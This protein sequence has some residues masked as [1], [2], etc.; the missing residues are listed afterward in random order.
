MRVTRVNLGYGVLGFGFG[1]L[2]DGFV[3]HQLLQWH[4]FWSSKKPATTIQGLEV[5][6]LADGI[7]HVACLA[8]V[9][10][11]IAMLVGHTIEPRQLVGL[12]FI[13]WGTFHVVDQIVF[14]LSL[15][16]HHIRQDVANY[17]MYDWSFFAIGLVFIGIGTVVLRGEAGERPTRTHRRDA[18]AR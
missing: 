12:G 11:G 1:G 8:V 9:A 5:N 4:H 10:L 13:G 18:A 6:T 14:H 16:A 15:D 2:V 17:A 3:L 7:F